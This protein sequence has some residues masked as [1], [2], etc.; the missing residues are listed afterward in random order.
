MPTA[1]FLY[2][3]YTN[4][5]MGISFKIPYTWLLNPRT[6]LSSTIQFVEPKS[7]IMDEAGYQ[8]RLTIEYRKEN[9]P[10]T[11]SDARSRLE[12]V[13]EELA[14]N[15]TTFTPGNIAS[16]TF[17]PAKGSYCYYN[18]TYDD[19]TKTYQ[20]KGRIVIVAYGSSLYQVRLTAPRSWYSYYEV[21]YRHVRSS[22]E[23]Q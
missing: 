9:S 17:G 7:E 21:V 8:T 6:N 10:Q 15:F 11:V 14:G 23:F 2:E 16:A 4:E 19:G 12:S 3:T 5:Q 20:M 13:L 18:A 1:N 22:I